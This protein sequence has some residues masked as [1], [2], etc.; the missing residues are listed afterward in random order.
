MGRL[1]ALHPAAFLIDQ[2]RRVGAADRIAQGGR[3]AADPIR[4]L[5]V[6]LK[7]DEAERVRIAEEA[8]L[9]GLELRPLQAEDRGK[10]GHAK[11]GPTVMGE[12]RCI[13]ARAD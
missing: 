12:P 8:A 10:Q 2:D 11:P 3:Q 4:G 1:Q 5:A 6:A 7:Q 9:V 13:A